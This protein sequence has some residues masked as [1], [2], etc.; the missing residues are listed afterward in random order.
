MLDAR[1]GARPRCLGLWQ[2]ARWGLCL[3]TEGWVELLCGGG[4][5]GE[6]R[7]LCILCRTCHISGVAQ[8][9]KH[10]FVLYHHEPFG[11]PLNA[12][13]A[14]RAT[15]ALCARLM[16][17]LSRAPPPA[18]RRN[19]VRRARRM[20]DHCWTQ[21]GQLRFYCGA[22]LIAANNH[23]IGTL[24]APARMPRPR[25]LVQ[26][27]RQPCLSGDKGSVMAA[28]EAQRGAPP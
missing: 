4:A 24:C 25:L 17:P 1:R 5:E 2:P 13:H 14:A 10:F 28:E 3:C 12:L 19:W 20:R 21:G 27:M 6:W 9:L 7:A 26:L 23:R 15:S 8:L 11:E 16:A 18:L 22:P